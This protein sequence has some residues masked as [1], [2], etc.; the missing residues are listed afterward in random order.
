MD[1]VLNV[2]EAKAQL[3][4]LIDEV[5]DGE[6]RVL[7][8]PRGRPVAVLSAYEPESEPRRFAAWAEDDVWIAEDF[9]EP[10]DELALAFEGDEV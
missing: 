5:R 4:R 10:L 8:G 9:D 6:R 2:S 7:I 3:S 1:R